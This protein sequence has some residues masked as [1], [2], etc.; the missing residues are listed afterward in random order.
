MRVHLSSRVVALHVDR[1]LIDSSSDLNVVRRL[2]FMM[3]RSQLLCRSNTQYMGGTTR[4]QKTKRKKKRNFD[5]LDASDR[6]WREHTA[7]HSR[8]GAPGY[9]FTFDVTHRGSWRR[10]SPQTERI[11]RVD[12]RRLTKRVRPFC[13]VV[14]SGVTSLRTTSVW[15]AHRIHFFGLSLAKNN[16][17][18]LSFQLII[19][20]SKLPDYQR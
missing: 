16:L 19:G 5:K 1:F 15:N 12:E 17:L 11:E 6:A 2:R 4:E 9:C 20:E 7:T 14:T 8:L 13:R 18:G 3:S 10:W